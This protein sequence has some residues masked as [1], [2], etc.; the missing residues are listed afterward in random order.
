M[1]VAAGFNAL[2]GPRGWVNLHPWAGSTWLSPRSIFLNTFTAI[3]TAHV[4]Y[5]LSVVMRVVGCA[6]HK[7]RPAP[8]AGRAQPGGRIRLADLLG[9]LA[10]AAPRDPGGH[11]FGFPVQF[12]QWGHP[13]ARAGPRFATLEVEI[14][15]QALQLLNLPLA[16]LLGAAVGLHPS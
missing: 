9:H 12:H 16:G 10:A 1:V 15:I 4:F 2:L 14:Y 11:Q 3:L 8:R 7:P 6:L 5:N 13:A